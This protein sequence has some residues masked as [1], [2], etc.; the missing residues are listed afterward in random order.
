MAGSLHFGILHYFSKGHTKLFPRRCS[1]LCVGLYLALHSLLNVI[2]VT[3]DRSFM[4][5]KTDVEVRLGF[6][7]RGGMHP[8]GS[9]L[10]LFSSFWPSEYPERS[11][12]IFAK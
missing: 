5:G 9:R 3:C 1:L 12:S 2:V 4:R 7:N 11:Y 10:V 8:L 6:K